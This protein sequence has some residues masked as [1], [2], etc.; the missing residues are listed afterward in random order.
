MKKRSPW[1][2]LLFGVYPISLFDLANSKWSQFMQMLILSLIVLLLLATA[3]IFQVLN[4]VSLLVIL[5]FVLAPY[6]IGK[7][8]K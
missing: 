7:E 4:G 1:F 5:L 6:I 2:Y 8:M 3:N